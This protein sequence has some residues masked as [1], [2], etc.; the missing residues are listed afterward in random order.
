M[1]G[2][3]FAPISVFAECEFIFKDYVNKLIISSK[4]MFFKREGIL[5]LCFHEASRKKNSLVMNNNSA[6]LTS[7]IKGVV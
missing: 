4:L 7:F 2:N 5:L 6:Y 1:S 3:L